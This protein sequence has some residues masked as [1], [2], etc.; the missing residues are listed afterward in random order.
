MMQEIFG[1]HITP[2]L[3]WSDFIEN[4]ENC[5]A[6]S[7]LTRWP[8]WYSNGVIIYGESGVGKT[9]IASLWAQAANAIY[10]LK[11][12][13]N[14]DPRE[15]FEPGCNFVIDN[16]DGFLDAKNYD[17]MFHFFNISKEKCRSFLLISKKHP[18]LW[19][20]P[21][22]D[23][24]SRLLALPAVKLKNPEDELLLKIAEKLTKDLEIKISESTLKYLLKFVDR[25]VSSISH[26]LKILDKLS[27]QQRKPITIPFIR[28]F[29]LYT[30]G[31][32]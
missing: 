13:L 23:L 15:F 26:T 32:S 8:D 29:L 12:G 20:V 9:H 5:D 18:S 31:C 24:R 11:T 4:H 30:S 6:I 28:Q 3:N 2:K 16:F 19:H 1:F 7:F 10:I 21:L 25:N 17:W 22:D 27:L 14:S